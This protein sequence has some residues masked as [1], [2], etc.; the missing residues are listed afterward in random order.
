MD[1]QTLYWLAGLLEAEGSFI[2]PPPSS[3]NTPLI[4][5]MMT[6]EDIIARVAAI[7][8]KKYH[9]VRRQKEHHK[10]AYV[11]H[12]KGHRAHDFMRELYPLM[13]TRRKQQIDRALANY[14]YKPDAKGQNNGQSKLTTEQVRQIKL[15]LADGESGLKIA[16]DYRVS[17]RCISDINTGKTWS[18]V[19]V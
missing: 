7:F 13:S 15:R 19:T 14:I 6:D 10:K 3:P 5:I 9:Q 8:G 4:S 1:A 11:T 16:K 18:H 12:L 17:Q 2:A